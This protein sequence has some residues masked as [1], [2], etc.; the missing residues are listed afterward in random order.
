MNDSG[1][2]GGYRTALAIEADLDDKHSELFELA[3]LAC[4]AALRND[5]GAAGRLWTV[6]NTSEDR[7]GLRLDRYS[8]ERYQKIL[9]AIETQ[10]AYQAGV[11]AGRTTSFEQAVQEQ[12]DHSPPQP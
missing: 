10:P 7:F 2:S 3:D 9:T 8:R 5:P 11:E 6:V 12:L 4:V 1:V